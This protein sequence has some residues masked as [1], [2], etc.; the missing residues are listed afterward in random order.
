MHRHPVVAPLAEQGGGG[1]VGVVEVL[2]E[3]GLASEGGDKI[4]PRRRLIQ[5]ETQA[6]SLTY[7]G[8]RC[9]RRSLG[10]QA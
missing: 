8:D 10:D 4:P 2:G 9:G 1:M 3:V 5:T 7:R 6:Q